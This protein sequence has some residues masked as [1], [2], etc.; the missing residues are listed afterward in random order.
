MAV[1]SVLCQASFMSRTRKVLP[2]QGWYV[3]SLRPLGQ[4]APLRHQAGKLGARTFALSTLRLQP[5]PAGAV[6]AEALRCPRVLATSPAAVRFAAA[7]RRLRQRAGQQWFAPGAGTAA[8][9]RRAGVGAEHVHFPALGAGA[10]ALLE[11]PLLQ[12]LDGARI[13]VI[14][15][16]GG[17]DL[18]L[19]ALRQRGA[20]LHAALVYERAPLRLAASRIRALAALPARSALLISSGEALASLWQSLDTAGRDALRA[21]PWVASSPRLAAQAKQ[22][23]FR[24]PLLAADARPEHMLAA[25][26]AHA[27]RIR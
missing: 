10:E 21:R 4:H 12:Q 20:Q 11:D 26:A 27:A 17:R 9:L 23:G 22:L 8:A 19:D 14:T 15:A 6:L 1:M 5:L 2:L 13:G 7:Q 3:I 25:L 16:P 18:L 24:S